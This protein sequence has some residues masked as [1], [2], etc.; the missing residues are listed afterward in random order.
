MSRKENQPK[1]VYFKRLSTLLSLFLPHISIYI[2][3]WLK[4]FISFALSLS[5]GI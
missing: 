1:W 4:Y 5:K 2:Y 3:E